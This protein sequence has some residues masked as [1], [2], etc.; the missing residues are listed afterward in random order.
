MES[1][2]NRFDEFRHSPWAALVLV[3]G[4]GGWWLYTGPLSAAAVAG[5]MRF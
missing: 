4:A 2:K 3:P 5:V 1:F